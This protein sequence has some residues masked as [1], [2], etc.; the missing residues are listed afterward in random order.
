MGG[1]EN[2]NIV[3]LS[4]VAR[5]RLNEQELCA[6][7]E[8][9]DLEIDY[10]RRLERTGNYYYGLQRLRRKLRKG[11]GTVE[12]VYSQYSSDNREASAVC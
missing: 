2:G 11:Y 9:L 6:L 8:A 4:G 3:N 1:V 12:S 10:F 7:I 5:V